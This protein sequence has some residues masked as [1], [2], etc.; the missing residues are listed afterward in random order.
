M[1]HPREGTRLIRGLVLAGGRSL[2]FGSNKAL[3]RYE[4]VSMLERSAK[5]LRSLDL[6]PVISLRDGSDYPRMPGT[7]CVYDRYPDQGPMGGL[8]SAMSVFAGD[9]FL[10]LTCDMPAMEQA[11]LS[12]LLATHKKES[13][14]TVYRFDGEP[15]PFPGIYSGRLLP[16]VEA[17]LGEGR[18]SF[19]ALIESCPAVGF[20]EWAGEGTFF[21]NVNRPADLIP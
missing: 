17:R 4:G 13:S 5:L 3:A 14:L 7:F 2:R 15:Q 11:V 18:R 21:L 12:G 6:E 10:V 8:Y 9:D 1:L 19:H 16:I 20:I